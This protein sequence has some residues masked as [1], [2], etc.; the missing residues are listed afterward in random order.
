MPSLSICLQYIVPHHPISRLVLW[1]TRLRFRPAKNALT[2]VF[3]RG[4][5]PDLSD[6]VQTNPYAY[7]TF[8]DF[9][10]RPL[11]P[12]A[13]P[14]AGDAR[15]LISPVDGA[16]NQF[17]AIDADRILQ[18]K[19]HHYTL[20]ALLAGAARDWSP[21]FRGGSFATIYLAPHNYHRIHM[22]TDGTLQ[23][24]WYVPG[25]LFC[26]N[27]ATSAAVPN[28]FARNERLILLFEGPCGAFAVCFIGALNVGSMA[29]VWHG[30][31]TPRRPRVPAALPL[32]P[33][34][35]RFRARGAEI[36]RFNMGSTVILLFAPD[37]VTLSQQ[38]KN[39]TVM[40]LG[41]ELG[42]VLPH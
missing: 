13:R 9:F 34:S 7:P 26:V 30:D 40:R 21:R 32:P 27:N 29:T 2:A 24:I 10:T 8:N 1:F 19:G 15:T 6:A 37:R 36:G 20:D 22:P 41:Q 11:R 5:K 3:L 17:G 31:V 28:L 16:M 39:G 35:E 18:A 14:L 25:R 23:E 12:D 42:A 33:E 38:F 4:Y